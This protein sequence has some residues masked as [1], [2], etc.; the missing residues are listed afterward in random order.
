MGNRPV[1]DQVYADPQNLEIFK[2]RSVRSVLI[3]LKNLYN[4]V[5]YVIWRAFFDSLLDG[6]GTRSNS[7]ALV[8]RAGRAESRSLF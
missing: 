2:L 1:A 4:I 8:I 6:L 5:D 3:Q 7:N